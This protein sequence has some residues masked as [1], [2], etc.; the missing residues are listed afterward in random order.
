MA[1][2]GSRRSG[3]VWSVQPSGWG[4]GPSSDMT[5]ANL[6]CTPSGSTRSYPRPCTVAEMDA[7]ATCSGA[8]ATHSY[9]YFWR[10]WFHSWFA[11]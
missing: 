1:R 11:G 5:C 6:S 10:V 4:F 3:K 8:E 2:A 9:S 7:G